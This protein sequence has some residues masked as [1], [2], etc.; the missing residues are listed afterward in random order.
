MIELKRRERW[1]GPFCDVFDDIR[2]EP[3][4][5][6][7]NDCALLAARNI[8]ALTGVDLSLPYRGKYHDGA[9]AYRLI[10]DQGFTDLADFAASILPEHAHPVDAQTGD[11]AAIPTDTPFGHVLG[12]FDFDRIWVLGEEGLGTVDREKAVRAFKVG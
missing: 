6:D 1:M 8:Y 10:R 7:R 12:V 4:S 2:R 9:S 3:I 11:I 5:W